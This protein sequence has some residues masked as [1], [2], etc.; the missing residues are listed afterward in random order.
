[1]NIA[2]KESVIVSQPAVCS[3]WIYGIYEYIDYSECNNQC[4][5]HLIVRVRRT[6]D[7]KKELKWSSDGGDSD[8]KK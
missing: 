2:L 1:M 5:L 4:P 7:A 6:C 8:S 3:V